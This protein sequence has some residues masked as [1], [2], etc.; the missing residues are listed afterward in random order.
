MMT[1]TQTEKSGSRNLMASTWTKAGMVRRAFKAGKP[2]QKD[3]L[4]TPKRAMFEGYIL[5]S[6]I[7]DAMS[8]AGLSANDVQAALVFMTQD[9][10]GADLIYVAPIPET[11]QLPELYSKVKKLEKDG[12]WV[13]LGIAVKQVDREAYEPKDPRSGAV[14]WVQPW[15]TNPR[16][17]RALLK[18]RS[19]FAEGEEGKSAFD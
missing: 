1:P 8:K 12:G 13:P 3:L 6:E 2:R 9:S 19:A 4:L 11:K 18:A 15:L 10:P 7:Q 5:L 16:A 14:V 17:A